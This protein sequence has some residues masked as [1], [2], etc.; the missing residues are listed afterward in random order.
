LG[1]GFLEKVYVNALAH[2]VRKAGLS[3]LQQ[4]G[5]AVLYDGVVVGEYA[6]DMLVERSLMI[7]LKCV[8]ALDNVHSAQCL[9]YLKA[10][11]MHLCLLINFG[12]PRLEI[13][14]IA[15]DL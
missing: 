6:V 5:I 12:K 1:S 2:E 3:V 15:L 9:N 13:R 14:R 11:S 8:R 4:H 10:T 7:E